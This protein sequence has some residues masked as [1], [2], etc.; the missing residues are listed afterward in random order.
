MLQER[1]AQDVGSCGLSFCDECCN[2][3]AWLCHAVVLL[4]LL[5]LLDI[6][7][8]GWCHYLLRLQ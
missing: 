7:I 5:L 1:C 3:C 8:H 6:S 2:M 4:L